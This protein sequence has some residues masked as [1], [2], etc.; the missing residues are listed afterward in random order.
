VLVEHARNLIGI[1]DAVHAEYGVDGTAIVTLLA[2]SLADNIITVTFA[3]GSLL[4]AV[5]GGATA[6]ERTTCNYGLEPT[7]AYIAGT[8]GLRVSATDETGEV[9]AIERVD[10]PFFVATLYQPQLTTSSDVPHPV[11]A[12]TNAAACA[13]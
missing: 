2:C 6:I 10:H 1:P 8:G 9:R 5:H 13:R 3:D 11:F 4:E 7:Y 12:A